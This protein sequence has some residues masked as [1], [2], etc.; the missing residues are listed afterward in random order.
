MSFLRCTMVVVRVV[1]NSPSCPQCMKLRFGVRCYCWVGLMGYLRPMNIA[2]PTLPNVFWN[3][4][5]AMQDRHTVRWRPPPPRET[6]QP[7]ATKGLHSE[8]RHHSPPRPMFFNTH[9]RAMTTPLDQE[10]ATSS[11]TTQHTRET[12][13]TPS[14]KEPLQRQQHCMVSMKETWS[15]SAHPHRDRQGAK[16]QQPLRFRCKP[17]CSLH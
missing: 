9:W 3:A 12:L 13:E 15:Q 6:N 16:G 7:Q 1:H 14:P 4:S 5:G 11:S 2:A 10:R 17:P 8:H